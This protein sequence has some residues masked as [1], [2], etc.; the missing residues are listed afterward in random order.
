MRRVS[1]LTRPA[2]AT[3]ANT[4]GMIT[5]AGADSRWATPCSPCTSPTM[6]TASSARPSQS[7]RSVRAVGGGRAQPQRQPRRRHQ[8]QIE[9]EHR[10][11]SRIMRERAA[12]Q[13]ADAEAEHQK[14]G[15]GADDP[16]VI[17]LGKFV[18]QR[19]KRARHREGGADPLQGPRRDHRRPSG[20]SA[21]T[22]EASANSAMPAADERAAPNRSAAS[23]PS[24]MNTADARR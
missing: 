23:P 22:S 9:P 16:R 4:S 19:G 5:A 14:A 24:T 21:M 3:T 15:P 18:R 10:P 1:T 17:G 13:R 20:A 6:N 12:D 7:T 2:K 11:P 8:Q